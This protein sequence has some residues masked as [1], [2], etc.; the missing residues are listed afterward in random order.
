[1]IYLARHGE[2]TWNLAGRYQ[3]RL[4]SALS[5]LG[6]RQGFALADYFFRRLTRGDS[7]PARAISSPL[8]RCTATARFV[9]SR[10]GIPLDVDE[11]LSE[12]A[13]GTWE[14]RFRD[15]L[16]END[17]DRYRAW[18]E[19]PAHVAFE[20][21]ETLGQVRARWRAFAPTILAETRDLLIVSHDAVIRCALLDAADRQLD[22]FWR[23]NVE[24]A[25]F[26]RLESDGTK[27]RVVEECVVT[28]LTGVRASIASQAL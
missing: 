17:P 14:G 4:E 21:G 7:I 22:E 25:A 15:E 27:F 2:T 26:A 12:V 3:G 5:A 13:H 1:L 10:L 9:T 24:N 23:P 11:R 28:H 8:L 16:A 20:N 19:D 6:V 18:R